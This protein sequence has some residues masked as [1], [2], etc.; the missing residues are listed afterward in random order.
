MS[1][2]LQSYNSLK[3]LFIKILSRVVSGKIPRLWIMPLIT[4][5]KI[6]GALSRL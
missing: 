1:T 2:V 4:I 3:C 5:V 6:V